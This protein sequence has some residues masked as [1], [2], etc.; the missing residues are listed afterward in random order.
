MKYIVCCGGVVQLGGLILGY[1]WEVPLGLR[2]VSL[3]IFTEGS[4]EVEIRNTCLI[5]L[6]HLIVV[7]T[8]SFIDIELTKAKIKLIN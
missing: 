5:L 3:F 8:I 6:S 1:P 4:L 2:L 7:Q